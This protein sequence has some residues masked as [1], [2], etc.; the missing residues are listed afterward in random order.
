M[1]LLG[2]IEV[3]AAWIARA[4]AE[5]GY[6]ADFSPASLAEVDRFFDEHTRRGRPARRGLLSKNFGSR[7]FALG[8]YV[9]EVIRRDVGGVWITDDN[10]PNG[11]MMASVHLDNGSTIWPMVRVGKRC[12]N[13]SEDS[14][15][16]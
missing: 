4:L 13:G 12:R 10:D 15:A 9:G 1:S 8:S 6:K 3:G 16:F 2:D 5:S 14:I 7:M 11:E